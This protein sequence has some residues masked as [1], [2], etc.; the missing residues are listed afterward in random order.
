[1]SSTGPTHRNTQKGMA[2]SNRRTSLD[3]KLTI[4]R[5]GRKSSYWIGSLALQS[6]CGLLCH[7]S[8]A[9]TSLCGLSQLPSISELADIIR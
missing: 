4:C 7:Q 9:N 8:C 3:T 1:M 6:L 2:S 5:Q